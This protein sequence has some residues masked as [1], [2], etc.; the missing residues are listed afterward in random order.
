MFIHDTGFE[1]EAIGGL[2]ECRRVKT[3]TS[4]GADLKDEREFFHSCGIYTSWVV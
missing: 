1:W 4:H 2:K 3:K